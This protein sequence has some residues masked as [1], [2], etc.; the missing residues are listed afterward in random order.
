MFYF[1]KSCFFFQTKVY[2]RIAFEAV[3]FFL[4]NYDEDVDFDY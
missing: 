1:V 4:G 2:E 3:V